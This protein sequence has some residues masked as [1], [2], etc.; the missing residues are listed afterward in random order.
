VLVQQWSVESDGAAIDSGDG[1]LLR[2]VTFSCNLV[3]FDSE[4]C[5]GNDDLF[6]DL[7]VDVFLDSDLSGADGCSCF[8]ACPGWGAG[9]T[10]DVESTESDS[11]AL[12]SE[13]GN[14][15]V[16]SGAVHGNSQLGLVWLGF[17]TSFQERTIVEEDVVSIE[18]SL[19][20][21]VGII[22]WEDD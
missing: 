21:M 1:S 3:I 16:E 18:R 19:M 11:N 6:A 5:A 13:L 9:N 12:V 4:V 10:M 14:I 8:H 22:R 7:P 20:I 17:S 2:A 15:W